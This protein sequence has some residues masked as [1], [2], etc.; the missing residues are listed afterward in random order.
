MKLRF[1]EKILM[2][3]SFF[4]ILI[5]LILMGTFG[6]FYKFPI[7]SLLIPVIVLI[8]FIIFIFWVLKFKWPLILFIFS[9][10][11]SYDKWG[12]IYKFP[13]N[14]I[15]VSKGLKVMSFNVRLFNSFNWIK[16]SNVPKLIL[17]FVEEEKPDIICFQEFSNEFS[18]RF[19]NYPYRYI[20]SFTKHGQNG[21]CI[22]SKSRLFNNGYIKFDNSIN[23]FIYSSTIYKKDTIQVYNL[24]LESLRINTKDTLFRKQNSKKFFDRINNLIKKQEDQAEIF[25]DTDKENI[26]PVIICTDLNNNAFSKA[27]QGIKNKRIDSFKE[28]GDGFGT[29]YNFV[30][31]PLRIDFIFVD[32]QMRIIKFK[33]HDINLSDHNPISA[34]IDWK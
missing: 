22:L 27:Y 29:T 2:L 14:A 30:Y 15:S 5:Q 23:G 32:P 12:K 20:K 19:K 16:D 6:A 31:L 13:N 26:H 3:L 8:N 28:I 21:L 1:T 25:K 7:L 9:F 33:T 24:H 10:F 4:L 17:K 11:I 18:P 34:V